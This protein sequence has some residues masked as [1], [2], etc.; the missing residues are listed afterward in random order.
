MFQ[1]NKIESSCTFEPCYVCRKTEP[2]KKIYMNYKKNQKKPNC[3][4]LH[5]ECVSKF[6][7]REFLKLK[8][9]REQNER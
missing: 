3:F 4:Y 6:I 2:D 1:I 7:N 5:G 8:D 9:R